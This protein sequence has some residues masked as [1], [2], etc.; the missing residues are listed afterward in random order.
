[1]RRIRNPLMREATAIPERSAERGA[2]IADIAGIVT[3]S[4]DLRE[5]LLG[6]PARRPD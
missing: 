4:H 6:A 1:M 5:T 2:L 3:R